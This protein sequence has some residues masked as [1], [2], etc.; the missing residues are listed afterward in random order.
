MKLSNITKYLK[1]LADDKIIFV[2]NFNKV[3]Y[4][5]T[6]WYSINYDNKAVTELLKL[7]KPILGAIPS[8][9]EWIPSNEVTIPNSNT[10]TSTSAIATVDVEKSR[11]KEKKRRAKINLGSSSIRERILSEPFVPPDIEVFRDLL[12]DTNWVKKF[13]EFF[14]IWKIYQSFTN[15]QLKEFYIWMIDFFKE[16]Y[17][18]KIYRDEDWKMIWSMIILNE[19]DKM[20][21]Y[22]STKWRDIFNLKSTISNWIIS[23][24]QPYPF[25]KK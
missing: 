22:Y 6:N 15:E 4:D 18:G 7:E 3:K 23:N 8:N 5:R 17:P 13:H 10:Y 16:K 19:L 20:I 11:I 2:N 25:T 12:W 24:S 9:E 21:A 1:E 14:S